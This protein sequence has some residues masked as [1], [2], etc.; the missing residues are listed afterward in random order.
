MNFIGLELMFE[1]IEKSHDWV[2][3]KL[4]QL[5]TKPYM[6]HWIIL[7]HGEGVRFEP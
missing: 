7:E 6:N 2:Q 5:F 4:A 1:Y 3:V